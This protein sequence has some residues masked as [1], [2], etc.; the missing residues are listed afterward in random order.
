MTEA[1]KTFL[2]L[3][4]IKQIK[5]K[6]ISEL[7]KVN[8]STL[9]KWW[10]ELKI[11]REELSELRK[12]WVKK[13]ISTEFWNFKRWYDGQEKKCYYCNITKNEIK[14]MIAGKQIKTKRLKTRGRKLEI[15]RR[16]P[17]NPYDSLENLVFCCYWCNN[18]K[19]DEFSEDEFKPIGQIIR[20]I[21]KLRLEKANHFGE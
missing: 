15:E 7:L 1:Q 12:L 10:D 11:E 14:L 6:D 17:N 21:W 13:F 4:V 16:L 18:A 2:E 3:A 8:Q 19:T 20:K 5:Y 9:S